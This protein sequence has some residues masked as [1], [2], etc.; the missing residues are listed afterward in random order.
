MRMTGVFL[1]ALAGLLAVAVPA[2]AQPPEPRQ[3]ISVGSVGKVTAKPDLAIIFVSAR[4]SSPLAADALEQNKKKIQEVKAKLLSLGYKEDQL[5]FSGNR[6]TPAGGGMYYTGRDRPSGFDVYNNIYIYLEA[7][8][9]K[10]LDEFN[11]RVS[12]VLDEMGKLGVG[13]TTMPISSVSMGGA[14]V[15]AFVVKDPAPY[16]NQAYTQAMDK[17]RP[18]ADDIAKRMNVRITGIASV[19]PSVMSRSAV[20]GPSNPLEEIPY[21]YL[22]SSIDEVPIR[23][24]LNVV[25]TFK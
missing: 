10:N 3:T 24:R 5:H 14:S 1:T 6:F 21:E 19:N 9:L 2:A 15:V 25:F 11:A 13:P 20:M 17:A 22:S 4:S 12:Q 23:V 7:A 16:E 8:D 18:I